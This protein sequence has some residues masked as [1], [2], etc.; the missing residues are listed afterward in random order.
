[1]ARHRAFDPRRIGTLECRAWVAYYRR[2]WVALLRASL[3]LTGQMFGLP[4]W[5]NLKGAWLVM[6]ANRAWAPYPD[7]DPAA[8]RRAMARF[9]EMVARHNG[10]RLDSQRAAELEVEW[11]RVHRSHQYGELQDNVVLVDALAALYAFVYSTDALSVRIAAEKR[12][13]L[14]RSYA[15][16]LAAVHRASVL[17]TQACRDHP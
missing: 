13:A 5:S 1:M 2:D 9:Y 14:V 6:S 10:E 3:A 16:L 11:W 17:T 15:A 12:A 8:A 4:W 7:N